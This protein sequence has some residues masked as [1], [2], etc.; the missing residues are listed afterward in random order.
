M[1]SHPSLTT[2]IFTRDFPRLSSLVLHTLP[3][4]SAVINVIIVLK[5]KRKKKKGFTGRVK[6]LWKDSEIPAPK[7]MGVS[8]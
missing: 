5:G 3:F 6:M 2:F 1:L 8:C 7:D 4:L